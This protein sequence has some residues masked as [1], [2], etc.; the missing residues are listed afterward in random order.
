MILFRSARLVLPILLFGYGIVANVMAL[1]GPPTPLELPRAELL[2]GG[3]TRDF[4]RLYKET[5]P[6]FDPAFGL[7]G[8]ARYTLLSEARAGAVVGQDGWLFT[9]EETRPLPTPDQMQAAVDQVLAVQATLAGH[10]AQL[11]MLPL[12]AKIDIAS[13]QAPNAE[14]P[15]AMAALDADFVARLRAAG[16][17]VVDPRAALLTQNEPVFFATDTHWTHLGATIAAQKVAT[18]LPRGDLTFATGTPA[19]KPLIGDLIRFVTEDAW[20]PRI[21]LPPERV[22][23]TQVTSTA[24]A[25]DI[26]GAAPA[27][28]ILIGTSYSANP[29]WGF[30][31]ALSLA[32]GRDVQNLAMVGLGPV[33]PMRAYLDGPDLA[34]A[35][36]QVVIWE[37]PVRYLTD[38]T[39]WPD[40]IQPPAKKVAA[41]G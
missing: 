11:V 32:L 30:A 17:D 1:T 41:N 35:P 34:A 37:F 15:A 28:I 18:F 4:E 16:V 7:I 26:F 38:P 5:L 13:A 27:D 19:Q 21:G 22:S 6:H 24:A 36:P 14:L 9:S 25:T 2:S 29:D 40:A 39:L 20:A 10:G 3:L 23:V 31:D 8:A 12:P 33:A